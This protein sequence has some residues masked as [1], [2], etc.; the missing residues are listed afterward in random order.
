M[1]PQLK[2]PKSLMRGPFTLAE[3]ERAG[4]QRWHL[5]GARWRRL[6]PRTYVASCTSET[7]LLLLQAASRRMP[8]AGA[9]SGLTAAWLHGL[10]VAP[11]DPIELTVPKSEGIATR[12]GMTVR[13]ACLAGDEVEIRQGL[14]V[15][16]V[17][18]TLRDLCS[19]L[20]LTEAVVVCDMALHARLL[21]VERLR[22]EAL[23][24]A[25]ARG[26]AT[27]RCALQ[28]VE[29]A[30]ESPME[31]RLRMV[32]VLARLPRPAAQFEIRD[33]WLRFVARVDLFYPDQRLGIEYDGATHCD[34]LAQDN[35]RQNR[36]LEAGVRLLR[37]TAGDIY[38]SPEVVVGQ[39]RAALSHRVNS[40][41]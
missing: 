4:L 39:V 41:A 31:T 15:T 12:A 18:R 28:H 33:R 37:F 9:F 11:C 27:L 30:A 16:A 23:K 35:R 17:A 5:G 38:D 25:G 22:E 8:Q 36:I 6:G 19:R 3:A 24:S 40:P 13:R 20:S 7:P 21:S 34:T 29:P 2:V 26:I 1:A 14:R 32:L 10:D